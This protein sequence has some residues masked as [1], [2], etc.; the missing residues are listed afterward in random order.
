MRKLLVLISMVLLVA[1]SGRVAAEEFPGFKVGDAAGWVETNNTATKRIKVLPIL[2]GP[3]GVYWSTAADPWGFNSYNPAGEPAGIDF[4]GD[5]KLAFGFRIIT[6]P[7]FLPPGFRESVASQIG[8]PPTSLTQHTVVFLRPSSVSVSL[9][10]A[11]RL[12]ETRTYQAN[13]LLDEMS[14]RFLV[15]VRD[16]EVLS[17]IMRGDYRLTM[18]YRTNYATYGLVEIALE[19]KIL[20]TAW[21][22]T[23]RE[24]IKRRRSSSTSFLFFKFRDEVQRVIARE[25]VRSGASTN[26]QQSLAITRVDADPSQIALIDRAIGIL[27][28]SRAEIVAL[29]TAALS[30]ARAANDPQLAAAHKA[31]LD[32][33][34]TETGPNTDW[35]AALQQLT[36]DK[37]LR[38]LGSGF[39]ASEG[40]SYSYYRYTGSSR[41]TVN[42]TAY[43][44]Y[45]DYLIRNSEVGLQRFAPGSR[46]AIQHAFTH[47]RARYFG[48]YGPAFPPQWA[49]GVRQ[50]VL[51]NDL[52]GLAYAFSDAF[53]PDI[54]GSNTLTPLI[55]VDAVLDN[56]R[57]SALHLAADRQNMAMVEFLLSRGASPRSRNRFQETPIDRAV[58]LGNQAIASRLRAADKP[59]GIIR[60][61]IETPAGQLVNSTTM[62]PTSKTT[63]ITQSSQTRTTIE[64]SGFPGIINGQWIIGY[65]A[66][67]PAASVSTLGFP[68]NVISNNGANALIEY[69]VIIQSQYKIFSGETREYREQ[70]GIRNGGLMNIIAPA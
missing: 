54:P 46:D 42:T 15:D 29:H 49:A 25:N 57:N 67:V 39:Q 13:V 8:V 26:I 52:G 64:V 47:V 5:G 55:D 48:N 37:V 50:L 60:I 3:G 58:E 44:Q 2:S 43:T 19:Q 70:V 65:R 28:S 4:S 32:N 61:V 1:V 21:T 16:N 63:K 24:L 31:Y 53:N 14:D 69:S 17:A 27:E 11:G 18:E 12:V 68:V 23:F 41:L 20:T 51:S 36:D 9:E 6:S 34:S 66:I 59:D 10:V 33:L 45:S 56:N 35:L 62:L 7:R 22:E 40:S 38:F 30:A